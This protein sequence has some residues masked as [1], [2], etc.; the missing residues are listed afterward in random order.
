M[1]TQGTGTSGAAR[2][3]SAGSASWHALPAQQVLSRLGVDERSGLGAGPLRDR[4]R[5]HG[6]NRLPQ[7]PPRSLVAIVLGQFR[8]PLIYLLLLAAVLAL[9]FGELRDAGVILGVV[10]LNA[11]VGALQEGRA[12]RSLRAL[13]AQVSEHARV[14]REGRE[15]R[16]DA[17]DLVPGDIVLL[18][19]GDAVAADMRLLQATV[20]R[21]AEAPLTGES[22]PVAKQ[23]DAV[24]ADAALAERAS[25]VFAGTQVTEGHALAVVVAT[26]AATELGRIAR[27]AG[28]A[29][30]PPTPIERRIAHLG[31]VIMVV[32]AGMFVLVFAVG[33]VRGLA[34]SHIVMLAISQLVGMIPEGLP[35]AVTV[36]L[37][38]GVRRMARQ[39]AVIRRLTAVETL[40]ATRLI[41]TDKTGTLT[42]NEMSVV[43]VQPARGGEI[44][45]H[46]VGYAPDGELCR[47]GQVLRVGADAALDALLEAVAL[48]NDARLL[49]PTDG[50][51]GWR[52]LGD[53]TEA[54]LLALARRGGIDVDALRE[55]WPRR[56]EWPFDPARRLMATAHGDGGEHRIL[57]KGAPEMILPLCG[58]SGGRPLDDAARKNIEQAQARMADRAL[59]VLAVAQVMAPALGESPASA[60]WR[61]RAQWLG[62]VGQIDPPRPEAAAAIA[63]CRSAGIRTVM[64]T[65][66][67][68]RTGLAIARELGMADGGGV[69][70]EG[71]EL[72]ALDV[73]A[74]RERLPQVAVFARVEPA[75]KLRIVEASQRRGEV[76]TMTGDGVN[77]AP[78]LRQADVGVAM[79][80]SGTAV[81]REA[82][83]MVI[84]DDNFA[85]IVGAVRQGRVV[86]RNIRKA[87]MLLFAGSMAEV[88]V[89]LLA[90][91][92]GFPP[93]FA[94]VQILWNNLV[95]EGVITVNLIMEPAE[96]DEMHEPPVARDAPLLDRVLLERVALLA[97]TM[98]AVSLGWFVVRLGSGLP[99][100]QAQTETFTLLAICEWFAVL[101]ARSARQ[102]AFRL[103]LQRNPW[104]LGGLLAGVVL[105]TAVV[106]IPALNELFHTVPFG[107][108]VLVAMVL[109]ASSV[110]WVDEAFKAVRR[111]RRSR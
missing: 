61:G 7:A 19:A 99:L 8:S 68:A 97:L 69:V 77:D 30:P 20:L 86:Y 105:Q 79:G 63:A 29:R 28:D 87:I 85:T 89:L 72:A 101:G 90:M 26:G 22:E 48:C 98:A 41:C 100:V 74:L 93:P 75:Q 91:L 94:A 50:H 25:M 58:E 44:A 95:T 43:A 70:M 84:T 60:S 2:D 27:L 53:P 57:L 39:R 35:V 59:R 36:A 82:A 12:E 107:L 21:V 16:I 1:E 51:G 102:S 24:L 10:V 108:H 103:G 67:H 46:G 55:R 32:A 4:R 31:R 34:L 73:D 18:E 76:V 83:S 81:A 54:A 56:A 96:G 6:P 38:V 15:T 33:W 37:A 109:V 11:L 92:A 23:V 9:V 71:S 111:R 14:R 47:D 78:A 42:R 52:A 110:L 65:G 5:E 49:A 88:A 106:A 80:R 104:L 17:A 3:A 40:G 64:V 45:V 66:D 62:L 13:Q